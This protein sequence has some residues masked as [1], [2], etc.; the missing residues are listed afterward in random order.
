MEPEGDCV[1][2]LVSVDGYCLFGVVN[3]CGEVGMISFACYYRF[4]LMPKKSEKQGQFP[5]R[6]IFCRGSGVIDLQL[7]QKLWRG[8]SEYLKKSIRPPSG[9]VVHIEVGGTQKVINTKGLLRATQEFFRRVIWMR[10]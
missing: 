3:G 10:F 5:P 9:G 8:G 2:G 6:E 4:K 1:I 7:I